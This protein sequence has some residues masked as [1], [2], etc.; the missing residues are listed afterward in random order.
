MRRK[1]I[2]SFDELQKLA[3]ESFWVAAQPIVEQFIDAKVPPHLKKSINQ[4]YLEKV[5]YEQTV[6]RLE[7]E[8]ELNSLEALDELQ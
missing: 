8:L 4:A 2:D 6:T 3:K 7:K 5:S 1:L